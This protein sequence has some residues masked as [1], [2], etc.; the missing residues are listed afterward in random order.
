MSDSGITRVGSDTVVLGNA[1]F[2]CPLLVFLCLVLMVF[3]PHILGFNTF[4]GES[5]R[6]NSYLNIRLAEFDSLREYGRVAGWSDGMFGG[7][8]LAGL[9]WMNPGRDPIAYF[10]Q[11]FSRDQI[12]VVLGYVSVL[13]L[14]A[15]CATA[16]FYILDVT[17]KTFPATAGGA[18]YGLSVFSL[19]RLAQSDV[20]HCQ[21]DSGY[22][23]VSSPRDHFACFP[24]Q[25]ETENVYV[26]SFQLWQ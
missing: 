8:S 19:H 16:Y 22:R 9:H 5:D 14:F 25:I 11:L 7:F 10:L 3:Y 21:N 15:A 20:V 17:G 13:F 18:A 12:F 24:I 6:L 26:V 2:F 1:S 23:Q 4:I